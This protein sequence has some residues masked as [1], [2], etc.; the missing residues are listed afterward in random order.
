MREYTDHQGRRIRL[1]D[2]RLAHIR[3][4][5]EMAGAE[6]M[7]AETLSN[8]EQ[9]IESMSDA[10]AHLYYRFYI[11]TRIGDKHLSVVVKVREPD[12]FVVT[13]YLTDKAK[14]GKKLWQKEN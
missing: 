11:G 3:E 1:T 9:V 14:K 8:P 2:E 12:A 5:P 10:E 13:A 4:H 7:I 6:P